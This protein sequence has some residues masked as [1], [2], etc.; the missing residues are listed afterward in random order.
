MAV[1]VHHRGAGWTYELYKETFD[2]AIPDTAKP[3][4]G[5]VAHVAGAWQEGDGWQVFEVWESEDAF[6][7]F[8][9]EV[10]VPIAATLQAPPF[11]SSIT[12]VANHLV[13]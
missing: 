4:A 10:V 5:L 12:E 3:P 8:I 7:A 1:M 2:R 11:E 13:P 9:H 6:R